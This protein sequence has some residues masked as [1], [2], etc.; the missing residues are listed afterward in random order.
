MSRKLRLAIYLLCGF[1][2]VPFAASAQYLQAYSGAESMGMGHAVT[3][4]PGPMGVLNNPAGLAA[5]KEWQPF[6]VGGRH[7]GQ[8]GLPEAALGLVVPAKTF[9][10]GLAL[11]RWGGPLFRDYAL[12]AAWGQQIGV[13]RMG[14]RLNGM[15]RVVEGQRR[16]YGATLD[17][18]GQVLV[19]PGWT[20]G[21]LAANFLPAAV[22]TGQ[23]Y[24]PPTL[25]RLGI[26][27]QWV[28]RALIS[29]EVAYT[30]Q[31]PV[32]MRLGM[33]YHLLPQVALLTG[34]ALN[35]QRAYGGFVLQLP[36]WRVAYALDRHGL[37]GYGHMLTL[38]YT[39]P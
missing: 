5:A 29:S 6:A 34:V 13:V 28:G 9:T 25:M 21:V 3:A 23:D 24:L 18:G 15:A 26:S 20:L 16:R 17:V 2:M 27:R 11:H 36:P 1:L 31:E 35:P 39:K 12:Q 7:L 10:Y 14:L 30:V 38:S 4:V 32:Q 22:G 19:A 33:Q 8:F 37:L